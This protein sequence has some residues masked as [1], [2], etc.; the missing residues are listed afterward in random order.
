[1]ENNHK[2]T[3]LCAVCGTPTQTLHECFF[4]RGNRN[5]CIDY[6]LQVPLCPEHHDMAHGKRVSVKSQDQ[7]K[8]YFCELLDIMFIKAQFGVMSRHE[9][10]YLEEV[11]DKCLEYLKGREE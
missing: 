10:G 8:R 3:W 7:W 2:T 6:N 9:R 5:I 4:G 11:K 1:M